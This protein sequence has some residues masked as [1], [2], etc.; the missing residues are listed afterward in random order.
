MYEYIYSDSGK[1]Y[2]ELADLTGKSCYKEEIS[3]EEYQSYKKR[4]ER[5][6]S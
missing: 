2:R 5:D 4:G 1:Y 6:D 3:A